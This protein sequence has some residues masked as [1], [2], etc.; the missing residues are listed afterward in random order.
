MLILGAYLIFP[1]T[2]A[3]KLMCHSVRQPLCDDPLNR[4][5]TATQTQMIIKVFAIE[6]FNLVVEE[7]ST[8][9]HYFSKPP[10]ILPIAILKKN[11]TDINQDTIKG[12]FRP[13]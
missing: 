6:D 10:N 7:T 11:F 3:K 1:S 9:L 8:I 2:R 5:T 4:Q 12:V 13:T